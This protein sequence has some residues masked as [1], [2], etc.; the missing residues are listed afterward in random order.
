M[1]FNN[2]VL[3]FGPF[4][5]VTL[6]IVVLFLGKRVNDTV[7]I[8]R[9]FSI[10]E[11]VTGG[12]IASLLIGL[13]YLTTRIEVEFDLATRDFLLVYFFTTIGINASL[14]DL[15]SGGKPLIILLSITIG[16]M[17]LQNLTGITVAS[18]FDLPT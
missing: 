11:P 2:G 16:Y 8:L 6:G 7:G 17:F 3:H 5:A 13:V 4:F 18:W 15:L 1:E 14:K 12:M 9:E 10:P